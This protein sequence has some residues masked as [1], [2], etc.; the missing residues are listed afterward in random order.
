MESLETILNK[1]TQDFAPVMP[2]N[3]NRE[4][5]WLINLS[6]SNEEIAKLNNTQKLDAYIQ[7][8][9]KVNNYKTAI[10]GYG[11]DRVIYRN[12]NV[13]DGPDQEARSIHLGI[14]IWDAAGTPIHSPLAGRIHSFADNAVPG[15]YGPTIIVEHELEN[16]TFYL[17]YGHLS[18]TSL[19]GKYIGKT[20]K[21]GEQI[22]TLGAF[23]ENVHW[24]PHLHFQIIKDLQGK[25]GDYPGVAK[26][27]E[28]DFYLN[29][30][31]NPNL[32]LNLS[33]LNK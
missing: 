22:A 14:D 23:E 24:P 3:I 32:V 28:K 20:I 4:R 33:I 21:K 10:G 1:Y 30:C 31:P 15:D 9:I 7:K 11:E 26:P 13:F 25:Q 8:Q 19:E 18:K 27:S 12:N 5:V 6:E 17:L 2:Y 29:N 16:H